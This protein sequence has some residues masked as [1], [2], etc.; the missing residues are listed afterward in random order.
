MITQEQIKDGKDLM[1][2]ISDNAYFL[3]LLT[4]DIQEVKD[5]KSTVSFF[6]NRVDVTI[7]KD[8][9]LRHLNARLA[10]IKEKSERDE[11]ILIQFL[12]AANG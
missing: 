11:A 4:L 2:S 12:E 9:A 8:E 5:S 10:I 1:R 6:F 7:S 3:E